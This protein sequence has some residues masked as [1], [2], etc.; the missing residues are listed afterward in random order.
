M[1]KTTVGLTAAL[2]F[3]AGSMLA[4]SP[5]MGTWTLNEGKSKLAPGMGKNQKVV[6]AQAGDQVK[7][8]VDGVDAS[9]K[10]AHN[11]W[12]GKFDGKDYAVTGDPNFD[13][14]SYKR[15]DEHTLEMTL[16]KDGKVVGGGRVVVSPDGKSRTVTV[17]ATDK[18]GTKL[19]STAVY[20]KS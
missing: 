15:V 5:E 7:V 17:N 2:A 1:R 14:R 11:E 8:T 10:P 3:I 6:Y 12:T 16:K 4:A 20:D 18:T 19:H 9:G 13:M